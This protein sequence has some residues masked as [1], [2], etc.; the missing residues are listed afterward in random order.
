M[1]D[2]NNSGAGVSCI[3]AVIAAILSAALNHSFWWG[4]FHFLCGW[5]YVIYVVIVRGPEIIPAL[6]VMFGI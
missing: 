1:S 3:G 6:K 2:N 4:V 5:F